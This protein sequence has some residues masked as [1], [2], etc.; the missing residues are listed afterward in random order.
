MRHWLQ[1]GTRNW[2]AKPGRTAGALAAIALGTGVVVWVNCAYESVRLAIQNQVQFWVGRS[3]ISVESMYG[4]NGTVF[5]SIAHD[6]KDPKLFPN[7]DHVTDRLRYEMM[8]HELDDTPG[9]DAGAV[10]PEADVNV[11]PTTTQPAPEPIIM[12]GVQVEAVGIR[13]ASE[14]LFRDYD[15]K[16]AGGSSRKLTSED[17][18]AAMIERRLAQQIGLGVGDRFVLRTM[19]AEEGQPTIVTRA[20]F[21]IVGL[22]EHRRVAKQ[23]LPL[24]VAMFDRVRSLTQY[25][26][27]IPRVTK[28]DIIVRDDE[29]GA[30]RKTKARVRATVDAHEQGF[31]TTSAETRRKQVKEAERQTTLFLALISSVALF[32]AFFI[33]LSTLSMGMVERLGRLGMLRCVGVTRWQMAWLVLSEAVPLGM[34][35]IVLGVPVGLALTKL[36]ILVAPDY[37]GHFEISHLG[38][39]LALAGG[40]ITTL[41]GAILPVLQALRI[42][43]MSASRPQA[44]P[45]GPFLTWF[46]A[47]VGAAMVVGHLLMLHRLP[48]NSWFQQGLIGPLLSLTLVSLLYCG[49]ALVPPLVMLL[50]GRV[51]VLL[52]ARL[53]RVREQ[54]LADQV[55]RAPWRSGTICC[56]LMVGLSLIVS[57]TVHSESLARGWDFPK[58]FAEAFVYVS[59]PI[60][61]ERANE[62]RRLPGVSSSAVINENIDCRIQAGHW[63]AFPWSRFVAGDPD[64]FFSMVNLEFVD[65]DE[66]DAKNKIKQGGYVLVT[67]EFTRVQFPPDEKRKTFCGEEVKIR[68]SEGSSKTRH[69]FKIAGVV[70]SPAL[71]IAANYFNASGMLV[72]SSVLVVMGTFDDAR[73]KFGVPDKV[74]L[75]LLNFDLTVTGPP[76]EFQD[77]TPPAIDDPTVMADMIA[78]WAP[79]MPE[80]TVESENIARH[81]RTLAEKNRPLGWADSPTLTLFF[82]SFEKGANGW[83]DFLPA[84]RWRNFREELVMRLIELRGGSTGGMHGSVGALKAQI[85]GDLRRAT[86]LFSTVPMV[87]LIVAALGVAN[88]MMANITSRARQIAMLRAV[89][90]T[91]GQISRLILG[92]ALVLGTLGSLLGV[93][94][95]LLGASDINALTTQIWGFV[96][97][98]TIP[99]RWVGGG[100]AFTMTVCLIAGL[101]PARHAARSNIIDALQTT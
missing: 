44:K 28:I 7:V 6:L 98:W 48:P 38:L 99:W 94:L 93:A 53:M 59:P 62:I 70:T 60:E 43:P 22:L 76:A 30:L 10:R 49:F 75:F 90:A 45:T 91:K 51:A 81:R 101:I 31:L 65:G 63:F 3:D 13:P 39:V 57:L 17:T 25:D 19:R 11:E 95:G 40:A 55:G 42:S 26:D 83:S 97:D 74:S 82:N 80:R 50:V 9:D 87:A 37:V 41:A 54:L 24:I 79:L 36:T 68:L 61:R 12:P 18:D 85:D 47:L 14:Y 56:G 64:E 27:G 8:L 88:L 73:E 29:P 84:E 20:T 86:A 78:R 1:L 33:I 100:V 21:R 4:P 96:P 69:T 5:E 52:V 23:Q 32:T 66:A 2:W 89:G 35:G 71:D 46:A 72:K 16:R 34:V 15:A 67:P 58:D 92:E 77:D